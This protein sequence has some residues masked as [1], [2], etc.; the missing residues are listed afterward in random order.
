MQPSTIYDMNTFVPGTFHHAI[1]GRGVSR[2]LS[3][4]LYFLGAKKTNLLDGDGLL[5]HLNVITVLQGLD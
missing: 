5:N 3:L 2:R 1:H 4:L